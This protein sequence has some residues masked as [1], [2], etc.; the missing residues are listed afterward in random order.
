MGLPLPPF[1]DVAR[2]TCR[3]CGKGIQRVD[4]T[5][6]RRRRWHPACLTVYLDQDIRRLR[7]QVFARD[8]GTCAACG[9]NTQVL[10][11]RMRREAVGQR[12]HRA[13][14]E[15][16]L[17]LRL[18]GYL[19]NK[20]LWECDH[21]IPSTDGGADALDNLQTLCQ[22]CHREKTAYENSERAARG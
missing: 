3:W 12:G 22:P 5:Q 11:A 4:G 10:E 19:I 1:T 9:A 21:I 14:T 7:H 18:E 16:G 13:Y 6:N 15:T 2:G 17:F 20:S 8:R